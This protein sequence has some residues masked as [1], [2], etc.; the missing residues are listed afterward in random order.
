[1]KKRLICVLLVL[2]LFTSLLPAEAIAEEAS[3]AEPAA[4]AAAENS[5]DA[6][7]PGEEDESAELV[8]EAESA[9]S[10][11]AD[12]PAPEESPA[13]P[14]ADAAVPEVGNTVEPAPEAAATEAVPEDGAGL[15]AE[16][17][18]PAGD[19]PEAEG[20]AAPA[21][22]IPEAEGGAAPADDIPEAEGG[23]APADD[24]PESEGDA[25]AEAGEPEAIRSPSLEND[26]EETITIETEGVTQYCIPAD[27]TPS[28]ELFTS[29]VNTLFYPDAGAH[30]SGNTAGSRL[31]GLEAQF[32]TLLKPQISKVA[33]GTST[34][35]AFV[36]TLDK[37]TLD[38]LGIQT[39]WTAEELGVASIIVDGSINQE[40][41]DAIGDKPDYDLDL[42]IKALLADCP[43]EL[44]W[45]DKTTGVETLCKHS[46]SAT[47][48]ALTITA[49][50]YTFSFAV[51]YEY[52]AGN[53]K[54][55]NA[56]VTAANT[57][58]ENARSVAAAAPESSLYAKI[59]Y[60]KEQIC[61]LVSYNDHAAQTE[62]M[63]YGN[64]WQ[65]I[66]VFDG[67]DSTN[68]DV[69]CEGY[70]KAFQYLCELSG[71]NCISVWGLMDGGDHMWNI[72]TM[73][74]GKNYLV[75][76]TN[77]DEGSIGDGGELFLRGFYSGSA[78]DGYV[79]RWI[80][81]Y[82]SVVKISYIYDEDMWS[83]YSA[84]SLTLSSTDYVPPSDPYAYPVLTPGEDVSGELAGVSYALY[85]FTAA[86]TGQYSFDVSSDESMICTLL[87]ADL[88]PIISFDNKSY[89]GIG[90][91]LRAGETY[92][93]RIRLRDA[94]EG[95]FTLSFSAEPVAELTPGLEIT[96]EA[97]SHERRRF[98]FTPETSGVY[99]FIP[100][101]E[102]WYGANL[103]GPG[104]AASV[105]PSDG[106]PMI[107]A[108]LSAGEDYV[109]SLSCY[110]GSVSV[111]LRESFIAFAAGTKEDSAVL[112]AA[113]GEPL[114][115]GVDVCGSADGLTYCWYG[116]DGAAVDGA[117]AQSYTI[118]A[119]S[120]AGLWRCGISAGEGDEC[121]VTFDVRVENSFFA[122]AAGTRDFEADIGVTEG[123]TLRLAVEVF[124]DDMSALTCQWYH[125]GEPIEDARDSAC[126][127]G[128]IS[129]APDI[130]IHK[131]E[132]VVTDRYGNT[133]KVGFWLWH[134]DS[135]DIPAL[136]ARDAGTGRTQA[137]VYVNLNSTAALT[138]EVENASGDVHYQ[139]LD[140]DWNE[141]EGEPGSVLVT[142]PVT[143]QTSYTCEVTDD[144]GRG[145]SVAYI[146]GVENHFTAGPA[147]G[148]NMIRVPCGSTAALHVEASADVGA[149]TYYWWHG[150]DSENP[151]EC[152]D[153][154]LVTGE[155][156]QF[157]G[158]HCRVSDIY[159]NVC[160]VT[161]SVGVE[162]HFTV[163]PDGAANG[164]V[165]TVYV[166][167]G[168][169]VTLRVTASADTALQYQWKYE[170]PIGGPYSV[171][172]DYGTDIPG[173]TGPSYVTLPVTV[174]EVY[175][176]C[177]VDDGYG[178]YKYAF[179]DVIRIE[180]EEQ[181]VAEPLISGRKL[182]LAAPK[183]YLWSVSAGDAQ[184]VSVSAAG[185]VTAKTVTEAHAVT[186]TAAAPDGRIVTDYLVTILPQAQSVVITDE[187]GAAVTG[188]TISF[189]LNRSDLTAMTFTASLLPAD[190][191]Q[192]VKWSISDKKKLAVMEQD[193]VTGTVTI[194]SRSGKTGTVTLTAT[195]VDG[196][197][198]KASVKVGFCRYAQADSFSITD[199]GPVES[200]KSVPLKTNIGGIAALTN[201]TL[202]WSFDPDTVQ[203]VSPYAVLTAAGKLV[204][205]CVS[206]D[207]AVTV[208]AWAKSNPS[209]KAERTIT[210]LAKPQA[211]PDRV[212]QLDLYRDGDTETRINNTTQILDISEAAQLTLSARCLPAGAGQTVTWKTSN[213]KIAVVSAEGVVTAKKAGTV[214]IT[215]AAADGSG[216]KVSFR[217]VIRASVHGIAIRE[218]AVELRGGAKRTLHADFTPAKPT[219]AKVTW[220]LRPEDTAYAGIS[221]KGVLT[222]KKVTDV[223]YVEVTVR[224]AEDPT[225]TDTIRVRLYPAVSALAIL[226]DGTVVTKKTITVTLAQAQTGISLQA[227]VYPA[228]ARQDVTWKS[229]STKI[230]EV[231]DGTVVGKKKGK[232]KITVKAA[233]GS[234]KTAVV[235]VRI[236]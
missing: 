77:S 221:R 20:D 7:P 170:H 227:L 195:A 99:A 219:N 234:G 173:A 201:R 115:L 211:E 53:C 30:K 160:L 132:C 199:P 187:D 71:V 229:G 159:G 191:S 233:D 154:T 83:T 120:A 174:P 80:D 136:I 12:E 116:P 104:V 52:C 126:E 217:L 153:S 101:G 103:S 110:A 17:A 54:V 161:F 36:I 190:A 168:E 25:D 57:A 63:P 192:G 45:F 225:I 50:T 183:E 129:F 1:M 105:D 113:P 189:D 5:A 27:D 144:L 72:V 145:R 62:S 51:A 184:Y 106:E 97:E 167:G 108:E 236:I 185:L 44:Y 60:F 235:T 38:M 64:P 73:D 87:D 81:R 139:W 130:D 212:T 100:G 13:A 90:R 213:K 8:E 172:G 75:D 220:S 223:H 162:T 9:E 69:V 79:F 164:N 214:T 2:C 6:L 133:R 68:T 119:V 152:R 200:G 215:A 125:N 122:F 67:D 56:L 146:V 40:A 177:R 111:L 205:N 155:I 16:A 163:R 102:N 117:D 84:G 11:A 208:Y 121:T 143:F 107:R 96:F 231:S 148:V 59:T 70:S 24:I 137:E 58:A 157:D 31:D 182:Q 179:F 3:E 165:A 180:S 10:A 98:L 135:G 169:S 150:S 21:D 43:Y 78:E 171:Y 127:A 4:D 194:A 149:L 218:E 230:A 28:D 188:K 22:D 15:A 226:R 55:D 66:W 206:E 74:D 202:V 141:I 197:K 147:D 82:Y 156:T 204:T 48:T 76:V 224:S 210:L 112:T 42:V 94:A 46:L 134:K 18:E 93:F 124:A 65:L 118:P 196:S 186:V 91:I 47:S 203:T 109:L 19:I 32:Y 178:D 49:R 35:T 34:D 131:Y 207:T 95:S 228:E 209:A 216:V 158:Y 14:E 222:A 151:L 181:P 114:T 33:A 41:V 86:Y 39:T 37:I 89:G 26:A 88:N 198:R 138:V 29:Y 140:E 166:R 123:E 61:S 232:V 92:Y 23:A 176:A 193:P 175:Y 128:P 85:T 142:A